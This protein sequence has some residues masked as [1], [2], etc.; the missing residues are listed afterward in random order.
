MTEKVQNQQ[1]MAKCS[2]MTE[3]F[4]NCEKTS[5]S[6]KTVKITLE[7]MSEVQNH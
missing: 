1:N 2:K 7:I 4:Q 3:K 6:C 5:K